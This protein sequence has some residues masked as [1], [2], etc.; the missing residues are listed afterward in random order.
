[1]VGISHFPFFQE[2]FYGIIY[3]IL[4]L[5]MSLYFSGG[6]AFFLS[7]AKYFLKK[8]HRFIEVVFKTIY[9]FVVDAIVYSWRS[10]FIC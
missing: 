9:K 2:V 1:M 3:G 4:I 7:N 10:N 8:L 5:H 6:G